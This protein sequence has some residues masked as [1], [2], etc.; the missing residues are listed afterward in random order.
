MNEENLPSILLLGL[1]VL[2]SY[3]TVL[4][5]KKRSIKI[6]SFFVRREITEQSHP[7]AYW[8]C[9]MVEGFVA[10]LFGV[11]AVY[12]LLISVS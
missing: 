2:F 5:Y 6:G 4:A 10:I 11:T 3:L 1:A 9:L 8:F 12:R 7:R